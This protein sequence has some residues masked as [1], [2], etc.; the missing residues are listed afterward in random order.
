MVNVGGVYNLFVSYGDEDQ[1]VFICRM[2]CGLLV[3]ELM[4]QGVN[5]VIGD[6][7]CGVVGYWVENGKIQFLVQ[8]VI[9]V[10]NLCDLFCCIV[11][12]G[13]DIEWCGNLYIGFVL[14]ELMMVVGC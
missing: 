5:L 13:K 11:V 12:V 14:V 2:G 8:E 7:F 3:I 1:V 4:G 6:Y 9:I 10:V